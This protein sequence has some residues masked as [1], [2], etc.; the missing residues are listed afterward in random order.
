MRILKL[1][2]S[3]LLTF[4]IYLRFPNVPSQQRWFI[5]F[6]VIGW[7]RQVKY[8]PRDY[9]YKKPYKVIS[10][11]GEFQQELIKVLPFAY[12]HY[13]NGTLLETRSPVH[14]SPFYFFSPNHKEIYSDRDYIDNLNVNIPNSAHLAYLD[15]SKWQK[16][17][18]KEFYQNKIF[19][20]DKPLLI[21]ANRYNTEWGNDPI[22]YFDIEQLKF[23]IDTLKV[24]YQ[25]VYNRP[26]SA[27]VANDNSQVLDLKDK[28]F[29]DSTYCNQVLLMENLY[30]DYRDK[31]S[32]FNELQ[33]MVYAN[34]QNFISIHGGTATL[35]SYF[36]GINVI[37]SKEGHEHALDEFN[38][39]FPRL[40]D[41]QIFVARDIPKLRG[42]VKNVF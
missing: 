28:E 16:V 22:S 36:G 34:C 19:V 41:T 3:K 2:F 1:F 4:L 11:Y 7:I 23:L 38:N 26:A 10:F 6:S 18:F 13:R 40:A 27:F 35:A 12:W 30:K 17:P 31:V 39:I 33:L 5:R 8:F 25:I 15:K 42:I 21:I 37:Y 29:I 20:F 24:R 14:M 32:T 9:I